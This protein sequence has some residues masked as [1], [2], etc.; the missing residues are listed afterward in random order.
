MRAVLY[1]TYERTHS[2]NRLLRA[3]LERAGF[4]PTELHEP[5]WEE[6]REKD[7]TYF[8]ARSIVRLGGR[9]AAATRRLARR[10][11]ALPTAEAP[12]VVVGFGGQ[13]DLLAAARICRPRAGLVFAPL[14]SL[15]E[16][17]VEDRRV[18]AA[19]GAR[20]RFVTALDRATWRASDLVLADTRAHADYLVEL[21]AAAARVAVWHLGAEPELWAGAT[22]PVDPTR[23]LFVGRCVPLHGLCT[24]VEAAA[25]LGARAHLVVIGRGPERAAAER[26]ARELGIAV[27]W[28]DEVPLA[29]LPHELARAAV[30]LGIF[31]D[32]RK[33]AMVV[34]NKVYHAAAMGRPLV[35]RDGAALREVLTPGEH[36]LACAPGDPHALAAAVRRLLDDPALGARLGAAARVHLAREFGAE[37][38]A[39]RLATLLDAR[40]GSGSADAR[41]SAAGGSAC[42]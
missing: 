11:R 30:V 32:G 39:E 13:L 8:G 38:Q 12:L 22:A 15:T 25:E 29:E 18:F 21:G 27:E 5:L 6:T 41:R 34:P 7:A 17:L 23:V 1:G 42:R 40:F 4:A 33:A 24:I 16:T 19:G 20:A 28:R 2:A 9:Y 26:R 31:G 37:R 35:T 3:A 10:W 36:C 14:V